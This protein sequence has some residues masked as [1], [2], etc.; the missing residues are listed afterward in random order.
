M[1]NNFLLLA[2]GVVLTVSLIGC[3]TMR[4]AGKDVENA[5]TGIQKVVNHND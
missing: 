3:N 4:G 2:L 5:G 1:K